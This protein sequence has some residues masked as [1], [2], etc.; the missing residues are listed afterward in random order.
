MT[1]QSPLAPARRQ[2]GPVPDSAALFEQAVAVRRA[3][4]DHAATRV[5]AFECGTVVAHDGFPAARSL[6]LLRAQRELDDVEPRALIWTAAAQLPGMG[7]GGWRVT[8]DGGHRAESLAAG[9][10]SMGWRVH[11][12]T[13]MVQRRPA[14]PASMANSARELVEADV[15]A[16]RAGALR[17]R[18]RTPDIDDEMSALKALG[19]TLPTRYFGMLAHN[20]LVG[21]CVLRTQGNFGLIDELTVPESMPGTGAGRAVVALA[22][23]ASRVAGNRATFMLAPGDPWQTGSFRRLGFVELGAR[24]ELDVPR[25]QT[26]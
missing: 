14:A 12:L 3:A 22:A 26:E 10:R 11:R 8:I 21:Y 24:Y 13:V 15:Q 7:L 4:E 23:H 19:Q 16:V 18:L 5:E 17:E 6:N 20:M 2:S 1:V 25:G 9:F